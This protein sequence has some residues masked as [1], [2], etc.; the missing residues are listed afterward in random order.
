MTYLFIIIGISVINALS[1][2]KT[3]YLELGITN[4]FLISGLWFLEKRLML[5]NEQAI[6]LIYEKIE[7]INTQ[8]ENKLLIDLKKVLV[9]K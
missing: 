2:Q 9:S 8:K 5:K 3:G 4:L 7:N 6:D 1:Y